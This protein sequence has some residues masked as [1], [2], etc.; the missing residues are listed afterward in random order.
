M[1][2]DGRSDHYCM[3]GIEAIDVIEAYNLNFRLGNSIKYI[4]RCGHKGDEQ[5]AIDDLQKAVF[6][7]CREID[8]RREQQAQFKPF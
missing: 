8:K 7:L 5:S 1:A 4:L 3:G 2:F 6:Y